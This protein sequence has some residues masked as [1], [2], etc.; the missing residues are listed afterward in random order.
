MV[1]NV[2]RRRDIGRILSAWGVPVAVVLATIAVTLQNAWLIR[3]AN[4][5]VYDPFVRLDSRLSLIPADV[6]LVYAEVDLEQRPAE[7]WQ[8]IRRLRQLAQR[9]WASWNWISVNGRQNNC[10]S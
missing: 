10:K 7:Y 6:L 2:D 8:L 1:R 4:H 9:A 5:L 3:S